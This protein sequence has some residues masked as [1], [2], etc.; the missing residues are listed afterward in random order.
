MFFYGLEL[1]QQ[2]VG[3]ELDV[4]TTTAKRRHDRCLKQLA[5]DLHANIFVN[6]QLS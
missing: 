3:I 1:T 5:T 6:E 4:N 2:E